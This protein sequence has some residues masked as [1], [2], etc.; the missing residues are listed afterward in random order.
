MSAEENIV[1]AAHNTVDESV[2]GQRISEMVEEDDTTDVDL[3]VFGV[4]KSQITAATIVA[5][6][7]D[8]QTEAIKNQT[9]VLSWMVKEM[10]YKI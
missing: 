9:E 6:A 10:H 5:Q 8:R 2:S 1:D 7:T 4:A 3:V